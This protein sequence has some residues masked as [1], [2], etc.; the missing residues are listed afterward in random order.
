[1]TELDLTLLMPTL[2]LAGVEEIET[3]RSGGMGGRHPKGTEK[4][5]QGF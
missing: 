2:K 1:M 4:G 3:V 5:S